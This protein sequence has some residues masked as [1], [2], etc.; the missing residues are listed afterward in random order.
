[1]ADSTNAGWRPRPTLKY[2]EAGAAN[3]LR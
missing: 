3:P 1:V 2:D